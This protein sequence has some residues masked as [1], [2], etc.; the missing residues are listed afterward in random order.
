MRTLA[1]IDS[2][3]HFHPMQF[4]EPMTLDQFHE[5]NITF[6]QAKFA[7]KGSYDTNP[8]TY[9]NMRRGD[10]V[11]VMEAM[12]DAGP[13]KHMIFTLVREICAMDPSLTMVSFISEIWMASLPVGQERPDVPVRDIPGREDGLM[14]HTCER[15]G[16]G[17]V[18]RW[19]AKLKFNPDN[20]RL[21]ARD[22]I[23][24]SKEHMTGDAVWFFEPVRVYP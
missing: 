3:L 22:D 20:N 19:A 11:H 23:D 5:W 14:V 15:G 7:T 8:V 18:T 13:R 1:D 10:T 16:G 24:L 17:K 4:L 12:F 6:A 21:L 9:F 2:P